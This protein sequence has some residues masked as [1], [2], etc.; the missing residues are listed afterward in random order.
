MT[1]Y[2]YE[3]I[4]FTGKIHGMQYIGNRACELVKGLGN[5]FYTQLSWIEAQLLA[6]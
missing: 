1:T 4:H 3:T 6:S 2:R 5:G